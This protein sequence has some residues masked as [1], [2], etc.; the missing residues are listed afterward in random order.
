VTASSCGPELSW[1]SS[2]TQ[3][4]SGGGGRPRVLAN[5]SEKNDAPSPFGPGASLHAGLDRKCCYGFLAVAMRIAETDPYT[6]RL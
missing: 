4:D 6:F 5:M 3:T 2:R 1:P